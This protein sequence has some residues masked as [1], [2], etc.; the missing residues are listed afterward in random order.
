MERYTDHYLNQAG[1]G[2]SAYDSSY[3]VSSGQRGQGIGSYLGGLMRRALPLIKKGS[4]TVGREAVRFGVR[5]A[6]DHMID[7][8]P[9]DDAIASS[10]R[11]SRAHLK[12]KA[13]K[14]IATMIGGGYKARRKRKTS[15]SSRTSR[16]LTSV[17]KRKR[18]STVK[19]IT[20]RKRKPAQKTKTAK[21]RK[22]GDIFS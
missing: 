15:Q 12:R 4:K 11:E 16:R 7:K 20:K 1:G 14:K 22:I 6:K 2:T 5:A 8:V 13:L 19:K 17:K 3:V 18:K 10:A 9:L 21:K